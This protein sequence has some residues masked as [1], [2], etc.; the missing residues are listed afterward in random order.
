MDLEW[1]PEQSLLVVGLSAY[2]AREI[3][4]RHG[5]IAIVVG[6]AGGEARLLRC[7]VDS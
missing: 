4:R 7:D 5:Q 6:E 3:G 2:D 1:P